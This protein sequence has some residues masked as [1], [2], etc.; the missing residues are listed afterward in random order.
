MV[1]LAHFCNCLFL[2]QRILARF[3]LEIPVDHSEEKYFRTFHYEKSSLGDFSKPTV[4]DLFTSIQESTDRA[5]NWLKLEADGTIAK[6]QAGVRGFNIRTDY[7]RRLDY[8]NSLTD[9]AVIIQRAYRFM[10]LRQRADY[11]M[12]NEEK[13]VFLQRK[14]RKYLQEKR[15]AEIVC[16]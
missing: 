10:K 7:R 13:I 4:Y 14:I 11:F 8:L 6:I 2:F 9:E 3:N 1:Y 12:D 5:N 15:F 16:I